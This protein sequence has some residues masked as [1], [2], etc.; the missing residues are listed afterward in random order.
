MRIDKYTECL[1]GLKLHMEHIISKLQEKH[2][3]LDILQLHLLIEDS[4]LNHIF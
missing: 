4:L 1:A 2:R 3:E